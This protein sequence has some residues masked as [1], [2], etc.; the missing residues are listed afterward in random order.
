ITDVIQECINQ[1]EKVG[2]YPISE[3]AWMDMGQLEELEKMRER[4]GIDARE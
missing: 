4:L 2:I 1:G 3:H